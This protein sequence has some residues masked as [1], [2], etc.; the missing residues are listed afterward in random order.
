MLSTVKW[1]EHAALLFLLRPSID[2]RFKLESDSYLRVAI[3]T[4]FGSKNALT[5]MTSV[6]FY[7]MISPQMIH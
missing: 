1:R 3:N 5:D 7:L 6:E 2:P 4:V